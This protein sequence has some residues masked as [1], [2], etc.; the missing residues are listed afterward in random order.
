[1][2][3]MYP[4]LTDFHTGTCN[5]L[6]KGVITSKRKSSDANVKMTPALLNK[7]VSGLGKMPASCQGSKMLQVGEAHTASQPHVGSRLGQVPA[8]C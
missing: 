3:L 1:M 2:S 8:S 4:V 7:V 5:V 6:T